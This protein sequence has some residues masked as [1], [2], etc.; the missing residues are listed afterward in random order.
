MYAMCNKYYMLTTSSVRYLGKTAM[1]DAL[2]FALQLL[3]SVGTN[4]FQS[5][6][7]CFAIDSCWSKCAFDYYQNGLCWWQYFYMGG[8]VR[9]FDIILSGDQIC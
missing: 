6:Y 9:N 7:K 5:D 2:G 1:Q 4:L 8:A 3:S